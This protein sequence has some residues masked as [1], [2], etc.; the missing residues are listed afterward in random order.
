M[1][2]P[3]THR[4]DARKLTQSQLKRMQER[5]RFGRCRYWMRAVRVVLAGDA[6][7]HCGYCLQ[8]LR[9]M[10]IVDADNACGD[11]ELWMRA[12]RTVRADTACRKLMYLNRTRIH[13]AQLREDCV[14]TFIMSWEVANHF[15]L[16]R[17]PH[18]AAYTTQRSSARSVA[19]LHSSG[20]FDSFISPVQYF[21]SAIK[22]D[23]YLLLGCQAAF[24]LH[25][26]LITL[27]K[28]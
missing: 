5:W 3:F 10:R 18:Y 7:T 25:S 23:L 21:G 14:S 22:T 19:L 17:W 6:G 1:S 2:P 28:R 27:L 15:L 26:L 8:T 20:L 13:F 4:L 24:F 12:V 9:M 16:F 11:P